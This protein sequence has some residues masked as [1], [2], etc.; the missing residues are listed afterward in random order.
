MSD[1]QK[2]LAQQALELPID[3]VTLEMVEAYEAIYEQ[4]DTPD[5][6]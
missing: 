3:E 1:R 2:E 4:Q 5:T 6:E